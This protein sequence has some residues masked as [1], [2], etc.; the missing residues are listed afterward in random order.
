MNRLLIAF[1]SLAVVLSA[2]PGGYAGFDY[3]HRY[4]KRQG[5]AFALK[6][7]QDSS[8]AA[9]SGSTGTSQSDIDQYLN[10]QNSVRAQHGAVPLTWNNT[11]AAAAQDWANGCVFQHSGGKLG[12]YGENL[13]AGTGSSYGINAAMSSW[14]DEESQYDPNNPQASHYTQVVWK[15]TT[16]VGCAMQECNGIFPPE[17][18][19]AQ[20]YVCEY[21]PQGNVIGEFSENVQ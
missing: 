14:T 19:T 16:Q 7:R 21:Y 20:Y 4:H 13:A 15:A 2:V 5:S 1:L 18:G 11:L 17:Y 10:D 8:T 9:A 12:P 6:N 3:A